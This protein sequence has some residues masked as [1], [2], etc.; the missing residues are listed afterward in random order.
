MK[1]HKVH[2]F[3]QWVFSI[4]CFRKICHLKSEMLMAWTLE[5]FII[6][7][8][9]EHKYKS[10]IMTRK[11]SAKASIQAGQYTLDSIAPGY[12]IRI[13]FVISGSVVVISSPNDSLGGSGCD[14]TV[15]RVLHWEGSG[16]YG[17]MPVGVWHCCLFVH[18]QLHG[19]DSSKVGIISDNSE[20]SDWRTK[21]FGMTPQPIL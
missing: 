6:Y 12:S 2:Q 21:A 19:L 13:I 14:F 16:E 1:T 17:L 15:I 8:W 3:C 18:D 11:S 7:F 5:T 10:I 20:H 4:S 9:K